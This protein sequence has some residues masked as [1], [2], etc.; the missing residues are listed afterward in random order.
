MRRCSTTPSS[1]V[2]N[3]NFSLIQ[4]TMG[5]RTGFGP[6]V[7]DRQEIVSAGPERLAIAEDEG[8]SRAIERMRAR[9]LSSPPIVPSTAT[10]PTPDDGVLRYDVSR[11]HPPVTRATM[12][13][14]HTQRPDSFRGLITYAEPILRH[15]HSRLHLRRDGNAFA[16]PTS[17]P[18]NEPT[19]L[20]PLPNTENRPHELPASPA[21][22][23]QPF[24]MFVAGMISGYL[25]EL[26]RVGRPACSGL[27]IGCLL[28][29]R[30]SY[31]EMR[32]TS[33]DSATHLC[34]W[35]EATTFP[36]WLRRWIANG[37][38]PCATVACTKNRS[39]DLPASMA[40]KQKLSIAFRAIAISRS[41][42]ESSLT[43]DWRS[44]L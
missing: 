42:L 27:E 25:F 28:R 36:V 3:R 2:T 43:I 7:G 34:A 6:K 40:P 17:L 24:R 41:N 12:Q 19:F 21:T 32:N 13:A 15:N 31:T 10:T 35:V 26:S 20:K 16:T 5:R 14:V 38:T 11:S 23:R 29:G 30:S 4:L 18:P 1:L 44:V 8:S 33:L 9:A 22:R 37:Q 39:H